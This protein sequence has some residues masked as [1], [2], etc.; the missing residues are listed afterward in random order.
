MD[1]KKKRFALIGIG[2]VACMGFLLAVT[3]NSKSGL[4]YYYTVGEFLELEGAHDGSLRINGKVEAGSIV[5][6][7]N[8]MDLRFVVTDGQAALPVEYHGVIPDTFVDGADVVVE[9]GLRQDGTFKASNLLAKC[10]SKYEAAKKRGE[11]NPHEDT[12]SK[13]L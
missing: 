5:R 11:Q 1:R 4:V 12:R 13:P 8:G 2:I 7:T 3:L 10:P 6:K 9:G